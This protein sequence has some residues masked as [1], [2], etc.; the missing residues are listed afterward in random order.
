M[1]QLTRQSISEVKNFSV[2]D[3]RFVSDYMI[4]SIGRVLRQ[5]GIDTVIL[6]G[7]PAEHDYCIK[8][9]QKE[10]RIILTASKQL[11]SYVISILT[12]LYKSLT[13]TF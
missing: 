13:L 5:I 3:I 8:Y 2:R 9:S 7:E 1:N 4:G 12:I 6:K 11:L 10:D